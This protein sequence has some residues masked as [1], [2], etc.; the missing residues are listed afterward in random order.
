MPKYKP[1][2]AR[3]KAKY[4]AKA[5]IKNR[6]NQSALARKEGVS[7]QAINQ[8]FTHTPGAQK[9]LQDIIDRSLQRAGTT[10]TKVYKRNDQQLSATRVIS[11]MVSPD[12][13]DKDANGQSCDF[14]DVPDW[15]A[16]DKAIDRSLNLYGHIKQANGNGKGASIVQIFYGYRDSTNTPGPIRSKERAG[17][18]TEPN[19]RAGIILG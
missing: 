13:K 1:E 19:T 4:L 11:A 7:H 2:T 3:A 14:I 12:G 5:C 10:L 8:R 17:Q 16:R 9:T 15:N 6:L 18:S